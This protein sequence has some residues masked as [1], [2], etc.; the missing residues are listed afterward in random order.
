MTRRR[1]VQI[2]GKLVEITDESNYQ[3]QLRNDSGALWSD[4]HYDGMRAPDGTDI[5][6]RSKH[7][8][9]MKATGLTTTDDFKSQWSRAQEARDN[10]RQNG[11]TVS[12]QDIARAFA[13]HFGG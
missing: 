3:P 6:S 2:E 10:Y 1:Y 8:A 4:R 12:K 7:Q 11:G 5:S 13:K 9:Y